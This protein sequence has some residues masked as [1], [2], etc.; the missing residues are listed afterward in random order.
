MQ[1][2]LEHRETGLL[3]GLDCCSHERAN[4]PYLRWLLRAHRSRK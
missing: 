3:V 4:P 2:F 1:D